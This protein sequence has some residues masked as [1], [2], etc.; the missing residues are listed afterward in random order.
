MSLAAGIA[1]GR[2][3]EFESRELIVI[4][5]A[6]LALAGVAGLA[7]AR[8]LMYLCALLAVLVTGA[9]LELTHRP[10]PPPVIEAQPAKSWS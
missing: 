4:L 9:L 5:C 6:F 1:A 3:V 7:R 10:G 8:R 2:L